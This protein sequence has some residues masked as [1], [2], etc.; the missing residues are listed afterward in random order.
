MTRR[1]GRGRRG[2]GAA[3]GVAG[4]G[5]GGAGAR[6]GGGRVATG[7]AGRGRPAAVVQHRRAAHEQGH[8]VPGARHGQGRVPPPR[9]RRE[10]QAVAGH[11][12]PQDVR[13]LL[14][15]D[16]RGRLLREGARGGDGPGG[17][18]GRARAAQ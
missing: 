1:R 11:L 6:G 5:G 14:G 15:E 16:G 10:A 18:G 4:G 2:G 12:R 3:G 9:R 17:R 7:S 13:L 8:A